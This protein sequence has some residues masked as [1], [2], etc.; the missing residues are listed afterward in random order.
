[1]EIGRHVSEQLCR[2]GDLVGHR[3]KRPLPFAGDAGARDMH[4][5]TGRCKMVELRLGHA[6]DR[7][8]DHSDADPRRRQGAFDGTS[9]D[10]GDGSHDRASA[11]SGYR[12]PGERTPDARPR[13]IAPLVE[14]KLARGCELLAAPWRGA[15]AA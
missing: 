2:R 13:M 11:L 6:V 5:E 14:A 4:A 1:D 15:S 3:R 12:A 10:G 9:R 7:W 8:N